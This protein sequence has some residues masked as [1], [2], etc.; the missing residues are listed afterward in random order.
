M[1]LRIKFPE[2]EFEVSRQFKFCI[3]QYSSSSYWNYIFIYFACFS[4]RIGKLI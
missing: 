1:K 4:F 2:I 3:S